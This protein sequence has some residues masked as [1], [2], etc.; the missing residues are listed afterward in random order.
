MKNLLIRAL[1][2][3][4]I[5][6][7]SGCGGNSSSDSKG[8]PQV[9]NVYSWADYFAPDVL[10]DFEKQNNCKIT[11]DVF[12]NNEELLAKMQAGG[13]Q[14]DVIQP[15]DYMVTTMLRLGMLDKLDVSKI[16][17][18][19]NITP[20]LQKTAFDPTGEYLSLIHI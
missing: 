20:S 8:E 6:A 14:F 15:S 17:N 7:V 5:L 16:P 12:S 2:I 19:K 4:S 13:A 11:Y 10:A 3:F 1:L 18:L 9:L